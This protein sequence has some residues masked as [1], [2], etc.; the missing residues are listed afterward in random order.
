MRT[1]RRARRSAT[2]LASGAR[3]SRSAFQRRGAPAPDN[4]V[5]AICQRPP[6]GGG[7]DVERR[8]EQLTAP[9]IGDR[10]ENW[11]EP[12]QRIA[13]E[14]HLSNQA[15][16][17]LW[18]EQRE[19]HVRGPP[20][21]LVVLPWIR[22]R[23][24]GDEPVASVG[25]SA[26][27]A[28]PCEVRVERR[29]MIIRG[30]CVPACRVRLPHLDQRVP[31]RGAVLVHHAARQDDPLPQWLSL[32]LACQVGIVRAHRDPP[33]GGPGTAVEP[34]LGKPHRRAVRRPQH[35]RTVLRK[36][37]WRLEV[38]DLCRA[39]DFTLTVPR[40]GCRKYPTGNKRRSNLSLMSPQMP[41]GTH[42]AI[43]TATEPRMIRYHAPRSARVC[44]SM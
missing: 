22:S 7:G 3:S 37:V 21:V 20:R 17:E 18:A 4:D 29:E 11:V 5:P 15:A 1:R 2:V 31:D 43:N 28:R 27:S 32:V 24:D 30:V 12:H 13:R 26:A 41:R 9:G 40:A 10:V 34:L 35:R 16:A 23:F 14:V 25:V 38:D 33:K 6:R 19:M 8:H 42:I 44:W 39:H 36:K